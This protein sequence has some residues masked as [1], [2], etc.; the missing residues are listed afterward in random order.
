MP[1]AACVIMCRR[2]IYCPPESE[3]GD[4]EMSGTVFIIGAGASANY[5]AP[6]FANFFDKAKKVMKK[7]TVEEAR[8]KT[9]IDV[10]KKCF[11]SFNIEQFYS[12]LELEEELGGDVCKKSA[13]ELKKDTL[14]LISATIKHS[15][16][17]E[18]SEDISEFIK[19]LENDRGY[20]DVT[21][22]NLNWDLLFDSYFFGNYREINYGYKS[23]DLDDLGDNKDKPPA[24]LKM[25]KLHGS[26]NWL[27][28]P[29]CIEEHE[30]I[31]F[32]RRYIID[33]SHKENEKCCCMHC[34]CQ[35]ESLIVPPVFTKLSKDS[36]YEP[37]KKIWKSAGDSLVDAERIFI[38]GY[39]F[40]VTDAQFESFFINSLIGNKNLK[41]VIIET[42][43]KYGQKRMEFE[44]RYSSI[45]R[46]AE[47]YEKIKFKY[48]PFKECIDIKVTGNTRY[49]QYWYRPG[50][51]N[52]VCFE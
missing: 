1:T 19:N 20:S 38:M 23:Y 6:A 50:K 26:L 32:V 49:T 4:V 51:I 9:V 8:F 31:F 42:Y 25:L 48:I 40:P 45:F 37:M 12:L 47:Q 33:K 44:D 24:H 18:M 30:E 3:V 52:N 14:Y 2:A 15:L 22:I 39:S 17:D 46:H 29:K 13:S 41:E 28:C 16:K 43:P 21:I 34:G 11:P 36:K 10:H 7:N 35:L 5:G 27:V